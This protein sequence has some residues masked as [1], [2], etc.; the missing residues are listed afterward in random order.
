M[1]L[2]R[3]KSEKNKCFVLSKKFPPFLRDDENFRDSFGLWVTG[4]FSSFTVASALI[5]GWGRRQEPDQTEL[6]MIGGLKRW[7]R[8]D[9]KVED[10][11]RTT[12]SNFWGLPFNAVERDALDWKMSN[13]NEAQDLW[14]F[15]NKFPIIVW[16]KID[17]SINQ[18]IEG[19][20][21]FGR[22][23][24]IPIVTADRALAFCICAASRSRQF[25]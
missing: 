2:W 11:S 5:G 22:V 13:R 21:G 25:W 15:E 1:F 7:P 24:D 23:L 9:V 17:R 20:T 12:G 19:R 8:G 6:V 18:S 14:T 3:I 4:G 10:T 16:S